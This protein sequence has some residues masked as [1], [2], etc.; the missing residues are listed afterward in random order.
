[1]LSIVYNSAS[2]V[3]VEQHRETM[4]RPCRTTP[5]ICY[6][7]TTFCQGMAVTSRSTKT[8]NCVTSNYGAAHVWATWVCEGFVSCVLS[9]CARPSVPVERFPHT[10]MLRSDTQVG[11]ASPV[12]TRIIHL[13][14]M[15]HYGSRLTIRV[16][17]DE[18]AGSSRITPVARIARLPSPSRLVKSPTHQT[19]NRF[20]QKMI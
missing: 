11:S 7:G 17:R 19:G 5:C 20:P 6:S 4:L 2:N 1:M 14:R 15:T 10:R 9:A 3:S 8:M 16:F 13:R 12:Q 18:W